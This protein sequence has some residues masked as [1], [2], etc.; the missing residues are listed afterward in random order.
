METAK[1]TGCVL[2]ERVHRGLPVPTTWED[3]SQYQKV[4]TVANLGWTKLASGLQGPT[5]N[6]GTSIVTIADHGGIQNI[7]GNGGSISAWINPASDGESDA[8]IIVRKS[9]MAT[10][11][12]SFFTIDEAAGYV[13]LYIAILFSGGWGG[14]QTPVSIPVNKSN[15]IVLTYDGLAANDPKIYLNTVSLGITEILTPAGTIVNDIGEDLTIGNNVATTGTF[16]GM[17]TYVRA[18]KKV[19]S[20]GQIRRFFDRTK[21]MFGY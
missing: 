1:S 19:L 21:G 20:A 6:G 8:G 17:I 2:K 14:W 11:G 4:G 15:C 3:I 7:F 9:D 18:Y 5:Y 10:S 16:D 13:R 12:F